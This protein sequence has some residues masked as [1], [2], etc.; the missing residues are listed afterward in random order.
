MSLRLFAVL[1]LMVYTCGSTTQAQHIESMDVATFMESYQAAKEQ[2]PVLYNF[3]ATWCGPCVKELPYFEA[4]HR[5]AGEQE[6]EVILVSLDFANAEER[7][8]AFATRRDIQAK[9]IYLTD[10]SSEQEFIAEVSEDWTGAIPITVIRHQNS[11]EATL[12]LDAFESE[13][14]IRSWVAEVLKD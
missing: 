11:P 7:L 1:F 2:Q 3:W 10:W 12:W 8:A 6:V 13:E 5:D 9:I 14:E 4:L